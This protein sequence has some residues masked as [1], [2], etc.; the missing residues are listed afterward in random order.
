MKLGSLF[1]FVHVGSTVKLLEEIRILWYNTHDFKVISLH[2][3][4]I[5]ADLPERVGLNL[6][7]GHAFLEG[8]SCS[9]SGFLT[10]YEGYLAKEVLAGIRFALFSSPY[11]P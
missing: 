6:I 11:M 5:L 9:F 1:R 10:D 4:K 7:L 8:C 3:C 2:G